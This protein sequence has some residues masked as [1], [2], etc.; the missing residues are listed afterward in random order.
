MDNS[1]EIAE[2]LNA[3]QALV[4]R[5]SEVIEKLKPIAEFG[6]AVMDDGQCYGFDE[7]SKILGD[8]IKEVTGRDIGRN[9]LFGALRE[10]RILERD[11]QPYQHMKHHFKVVIKQ[12]PA[13]MKKTTL[14]TGAGL[15]WILPKLLEYYHG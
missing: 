7:A 6:Q 3:S 10:T 11:N 8:K 5:L 1:M 14:F 2:V 15:A 13:G 12:T 9:R 4:I